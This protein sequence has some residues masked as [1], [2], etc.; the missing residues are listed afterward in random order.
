MEIDAKAKNKF[1]QI[2]FDILTDGE[3]TFDI[4]MS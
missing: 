1:Y 4:L 2:E 3:L